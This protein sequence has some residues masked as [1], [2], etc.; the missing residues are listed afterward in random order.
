[1][2]RH[3]VLEIISNILGE[4]V[5]GPVPLTELLILMG[6][7]ARTCSPGGQPRLHPRRRRIAC[8]PSFAFV[9]LCQPISCTE[10]NIA[11]LSIKHYLQQYFL[12]FKEN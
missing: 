9:M 4:R 3:C 8:T 10:E 2:D 6:A 1:M 12:I 5:K 7:C 11:C